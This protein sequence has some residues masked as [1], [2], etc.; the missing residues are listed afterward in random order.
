LIRRFSIDSFL[1]K[2]KVRL[3]IPSSNWNLSDFSRSNTLKIPLNFENLD[4]SSI[5]FHCTLKNIYQIYLTQISHFEIIQYLNPMRLIIADLILVCCVYKLMLC[6]LR[7]KS[8]GG[9]GLNPTGF[10]FSVLSSKVQQHLATVL[11]L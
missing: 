11:I 4:K 5:N 2:T 10:I 6:H 3:N 1:I 9:H 7:Y 8:T